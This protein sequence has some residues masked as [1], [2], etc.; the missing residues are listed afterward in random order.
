MQR[1]LGRGFPRLALRSWSLLVTCVVEGPRLTLCSE[2]VDRTVGDRNNKDPCTPPTPKGPLPI[3][4][5]K[6][7]GLRPKASV[8]SGSFQSC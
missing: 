6:S 7:V 1:L 4:L 3:L 8:A 2:E 5:K